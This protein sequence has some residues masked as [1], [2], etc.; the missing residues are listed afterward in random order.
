MARVIARQLHPPRGATQQ[1]DLVMLLQGLDMPG[2][3]RL[4]DEQASGSAGKTALAGH[5]VECAELEQVHCL[6]AS[7]IARITTNNLIDNKANRN[8]CPVSR[9]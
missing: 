4:A 7:L 8:L 1:R 6:S 9:Q 3:R 5:G 2:D